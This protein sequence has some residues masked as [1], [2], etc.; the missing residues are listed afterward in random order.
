[1]IRRFAGRAPAVVRTLLLAGLAVA[2]AADARAQ[3]AAPSNTAPPGWVFTPSFGVTEAWD[4]NVLLTIEESQP[5]GDYFTALSPRGTLGF[6]GRR[7]T[8]NLDY[9]AAFQL[10]QRR[11]ELNGIDQRAQV[12]VRHRLTRAVTAF[13]NNS[14]AKS[15]TTDEIELPG[16]QFRRQGVLLDDFRG[17]L[18]TRLSARTLLSTAY[19]F[20]FVDFEDIE[21]DP[22]GLL[23][24]GGNAHGA[25]VVLTH[26]LRPRIQIGGEGDWRRS[27][28]NGGQPAPGLDG[29]QPAPGT[30][31]VP[32]E[33]TISNFLATTELRLRERLEL[34]A[35]AGLSQLT[36]SDTGESR[37]A[38]GFRVSVSGSSERIGWN[39]GYRRSFLPSF[40]F[41]GTFE[42]EELTGGVLATI[43]RRVDVS[44]SLS[45][46]E[47]D[48]LDEGPSLRSIWT[49][50]SV[51]YRATRWLR[52]EGYYAHVLQDSRRAGGRVDRTRL[53]IQVVT[54][55]RMRIR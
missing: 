28:L 47:N 38:P 25:G 19:T 22:L 36:T 32:L 31:T 34:S 17:G 29:G 52:V 39:V 27:T 16:V 11:S 23:R 7:T 30:P 13:A 10:Y 8:F 3:Q 26:Q 48:P 40:G 20:Q 55:K 46:R 50:S 18:D 6:R 35:G 43:T 2:A 24:D 4:D 53:G 54:S 5:T 12:G 37:T 15:P 1:M 51:S 41:G 21:G 44:G 49:R 14:L 45:V 33:F 42:N 9:G